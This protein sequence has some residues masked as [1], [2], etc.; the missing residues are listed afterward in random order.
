MLHLS[1]ITKSKIYP[2]LSAHFIISLLNSVYRIDSRQ[3]I[4]SRA[5]LVNLL[6]IVCLNRS[7]H[8]TLNQIVTPQSGS[9]LSKPYHRTLG[10]YTLPTRTRTEDS[11]SGFLTNRLLALEKIQCF[12]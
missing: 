2:I 10:T 5:L 9:V 3:T 6:G 7:I 12:L 11:R 4:S 1:P 8:P